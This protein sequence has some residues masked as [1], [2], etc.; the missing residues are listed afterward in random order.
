MYNLKNEITQTKKKYMLFNLTWVYGESQMTIH[1][2]KL[3]INKIM[4]PIL[5]IAL[6]LHLHIYNSILYNF[7][8]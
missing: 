5:Y 8:I 1:N 2:S 4:F 3:M 6:Q 7:M